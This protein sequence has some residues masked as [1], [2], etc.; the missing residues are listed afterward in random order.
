MEKPGVVLGQDGQ[1][2]LIRHGGAY[3]LVHPCQLK[4]EKVIS[5]AM[6]KQEHIKNGF[7][8]GSSS[9]HCVD[10]TEDSNVITSKGDN[11]M[12]FQIVI[13]YLVM[14]KVI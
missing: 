3:Y 1:F 7:C 6:H 11:G 14:L 10:E 2:V 8:K 4:K 5:Q 12:I 9:S 13:M